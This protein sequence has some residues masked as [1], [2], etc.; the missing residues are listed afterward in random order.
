MLNQM[1]TLVRI[2]RCCTLLWLLGPGIAQGEWT[3]VE[4]E[5]GDLQADWEFA[6]GTRESKSNSLS[7]QI[8]ERTPSGLSIGGLIAYH[9]LR[10]DDASGSGSTKFE[11]QQLGIY[12]RQ[13]FVLGESVSLEGMVDYGYYLGQENTDDDRAELDWSQFGVELGLA[14]RFDNLRITPFAS[15]THLDG[16]TDDLEGGGSFELEDPYNSGVRF[17]I[18]TEKTAFVRIQLQAGSQTGGYLSFVRRY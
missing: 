17:D 2:A 11:A 1:R 16:D 10:L 7:L 4:F 9:S 18:F 15:Y 8:E 3:G 12:L 13:E 6:D 14:F 5:I